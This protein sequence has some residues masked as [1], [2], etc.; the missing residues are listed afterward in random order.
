VRNVTGKVTGKVALKL[1]LSMKSNP[2]V[3]GA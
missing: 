2:N 3:A 1:E